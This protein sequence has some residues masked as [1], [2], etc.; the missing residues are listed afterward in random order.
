MFSPSLSFLVLALCLAAGGATSDPLSEEV[1]TVAVVGRTDGMTDGM[2]DGP[3]SFT[4]L[5]GERKLL[6]KTINEKYLLAGT[7]ASAVANA[8][9]STEYTVKVSLKKTLRDS[10]ID[11]YVTAGE[12]CEDTGTLT[13]GWEVPTEEFNTGKVE[14][15]GT[16][17]L[18]YGELKGDYSWKTKTN[19]YLT[20]FDKYCVIIDCEHYMQTCGKVTGSFTI[21]ERS[22]SSFFNAGAGRYSDRALGSV[23]GA[24]VLA[25]AFLFLGTGW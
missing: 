24:V 11:V 6:R 3:D 20:G 18:G 5:G 7:K 10:N 4:L 1:G 2:T 14:W 19:E 8:D 17:S 12:E 16:K 21:T 9:N 25:G 13:A 23:T 22:E 15:H